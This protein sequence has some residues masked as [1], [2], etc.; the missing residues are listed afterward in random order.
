MKLIEKKIK[1]GKTEAIEDV[2]DEEPEEEPKT[3]NF[4]DVLKQASR[5]VSAAQAGPN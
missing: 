3:I 2:E 4:M 5:R 1:S